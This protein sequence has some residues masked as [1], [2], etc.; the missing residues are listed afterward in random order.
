MPEG[1]DRMIQAFC[2]WLDVNILITLREEL[3]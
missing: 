3:G 2:G 1:P